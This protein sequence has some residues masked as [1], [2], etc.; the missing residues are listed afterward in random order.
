MPKGKV[1][2][3]YEKG[4]IDTMLKNGDSFRKIAQNLQRSHNAIMNYSRNSKQ[5]GR[6]NPGGRP[7]VI[8]NKNRRRILRA[9][10]NF[11]GNARELKSSLGVEAS[12]RTVQRVLKSSRNLKRKKMI[13]KPLLQKRH[14]EERL[15]FA[16][17]NME[18]GENWKKVIFSD[19]KKFNLDGPDGFNF[20]FHDL[21]KEE[22]ILSNRHSGGGSVMVWAAIGFDNMSNIQIIKG[23][24]NANKYL[25]T[26][27]TFFKEEIFQTN[28]N[29]LIFQQDNAPIHKAK[30]VMDYFKAEG[31]EIMDWP[32]LSPDLNPIENVWGLLVKSVYANGRQF[33]NVEELES[34]IRQSWANINKT[35]IQAMYNSMKDRIYSLILN[36]GKWTKY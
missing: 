23:R 27:S 32:A 3:E 11:K 30:V 16:K 22:L 13:R 26:L 2:S 24:I 33:S 10:S 20:Y 31:I 25:E 36:K 14:I 35:A 18:M 9:A 21:R 17:N 7:K 4:Q 15:K 28:K 12:L 1:L 29:N 34:S 6:K 5:Y 8:T 19:E